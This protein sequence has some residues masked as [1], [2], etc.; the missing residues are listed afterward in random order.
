MTVAGI[1]VVI[2]QSRSM[3]LITVKKM[4]RHRMLAEKNV[5]TS[6]A[7]TLLLRGEADMSMKSSIVIIMRRNFSF[8]INSVVLLKLHFFITCNIFNKRYCI[9]VDFFSYVSSKN[10]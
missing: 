3:Q 8:D 6:G 10:S 4:K 9:F 5:A 7:D 1:R 2:S